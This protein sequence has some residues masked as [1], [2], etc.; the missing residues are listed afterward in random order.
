MTV[1]N[2]VQVFEPALDLARNFVTEVLEELESSEYI[3][4]SNVDEVENKSRDGFMAFTEG[5]FEGIGYAD[6][7]SDYG[8]GNAPKVIQPYIDSSLKDAQ[9]YWDEENPEHLY[10]WIFDNE[11]DEIAKT[12]LSMLEGYNPTPRE[13]WAEKYYEYEDESL[14]EGGTYFYKARVLFY[15]EDN[16]R[17]ETGEPEAYFM[18][19]INTDFEYGRD[20]ISWAGGNQTEWLWEKNIPIKDLTQELIDTFVEE[21]NKAFANA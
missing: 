14:Q 3:Y 4:S 13:V 1:T 2:D 7:R 17:N 9:T 12:Q 8:T 10:E 16:R 18:I 20:N 21:A 15:D 19:G 11:A 6:L 5:G